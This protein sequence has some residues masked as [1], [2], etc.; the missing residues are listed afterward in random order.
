MLNEVEMAELQ[1][2]LVEESIKRY[3]EVSKLE[4]IYYARLKNL[5][6]GDVYG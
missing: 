3:R 6:D 2:Q 4:L 5:S 1:W